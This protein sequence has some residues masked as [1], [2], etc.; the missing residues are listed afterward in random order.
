MVWKKGRKSS[1]SAEKEKLL[2]ATGFWG[3]CSKADNST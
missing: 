2:G 1:K 3:R